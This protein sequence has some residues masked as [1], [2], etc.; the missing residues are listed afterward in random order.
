MNS[1]PLSGDFHGFLVFRLCLARIFFVPR[2]PLPE[3]KLMPSCWKIFHAD[4]YRNR[5]VLFGVLSSANACRSG[6][7]CALL[8]RQGVASF[9][10]N[11]A[12]PPPPTPPP[13]TKPHPT[14]LP[15]H[16]PNNTKHNTPTQKQTPPPPPPPP[17]PPP[18]HPPT[19]PNLLYLGSFCVLA[20]PSS[21]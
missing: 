3:V 15:T 14:P 1:L 5:R 2:I 4:R 17:N 9:P 13:P 12:Q 19:P 8:E 10:R 16:Q 7:S 20:G 6:Q 21:Y 11:F 18:P